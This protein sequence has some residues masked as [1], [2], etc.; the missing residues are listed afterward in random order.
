MTSPEQK[1]PQIA[2]NQVQATKKVVIEGPA[3]LAN[4]VNKDGKEYTVIDILGEKL[5]PSNPNKIPDGIY[6]KIVTKLNSG[7]DRLFLGEMLSAN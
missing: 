7:K 4:R 5:F 6:M 3:K 2:L 1:N